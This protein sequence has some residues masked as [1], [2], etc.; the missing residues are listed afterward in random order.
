MRNVLVALLF[1]AGS[2]A[3]ADDD[4]AARF[5]ARPV[6]TSVALSPDGDKIAYVGAYKT[7][8]KAVYVAD[9][10]TGSTEAMLAGSSLELRPYS[11]TFK[12]E[13]RL[14]C[15]VYGVS[16]FGASNG[17][18]T[19][20]IA[21]DTDGKNIKMLSQRAGDRQEVTFG[22]G[23]V[24]NML[25]DDPKHVLMEVQVG[26][27]ETVGSAIRRPDEGTGMAMVD[28]DTGTQRLVEPSRAR[29]AE[30]GA[31]EAGNV[32]F[33]G[34]VNADSDGVVR[35]RI[36]YAVR[37]KGSKEWQPLALTKISDARSTSYEGFDASGDHIYE[38]ASLDGRTALFA[39]ATDGSGTRT[40]VYAHP[41]VDV[42]GI[43]RIGKD[44]RPVGAIYA[45]D[46]YRIHYFD[47][48]L[49]TLSAK[50][51]R[52]LPVHPDIAIVDESWDAT[53]KLVRADGDS[54]PG[55]YYL[56][57][58][59]TKKL[60]ELI[61]V[62]PGLD[63]VALGLVKAVSFPAHDGTTIPGFLTLPPGRSDMRGL[64]GLVMPHGGPS[65]RD[66]AGFDWLPQFFAAQGFAVLQPN[67]RGSAGYG[68]AFFARNGF[69]SWEVAIGD[70][71]DGGRWLVA[72]G[73]ESKRLAIFGWSYGGYAALQANVVEPH[74]YRATVAV[75]P[76]TDLELLR[77]EAQRNGNFLIVDGEV[78]SG[79]HVFAGSPAR[80]AAAFAAPVLMF[81]GD[82]D[83]N[84]E[85]EQSRYMASQLR[86]AGKPVELVEFK[87]LNHQLDDSAVR[88][89]M[90]A[91]SAAFLK[92]AVN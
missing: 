89:E 38:R 51:S 7:G 85:I 48:D 61:A 65:A 33:R 13:T 75:A 80:H 62:Y 84:V 49:A 15:T 21:V 6:A 20:V 46:R 10:K 44:D 27:T 66:T 53:K 26:Y 25:P 23:A 35:D 54:T 30:L 1:V 28:V 58:A 67:F 50:L 24:R 19:R 71:N 90:L 56:Y 34:T 22:G 47:P 52:A 74:L 8:G 45:D 37:A 12:R 43:E 63:G 16:S 82:R 31:D 32:R 5:A 11:C 55:R 64:P 68:D 76:V 87:N 86:A 40:L 57:D 92:A 59:T 91:K 29:V 83:L 14:I 36:A 42:S 79:P 72:Q 81:H 41:N 78:G 2:P 60:G 69:K 77:T 9:L 17:D 88:A 73:V 3:L 39:V 18:Y 70:V 4:L